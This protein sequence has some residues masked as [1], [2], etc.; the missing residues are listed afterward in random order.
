MQCRREECRTREKSF[1]QRLC[2]RFAEGQERGE[3]KEREKPAE[4]F[5]FSGF[6]RSINLLGRLQIFGWFVG[7]GLTVP[8]GL[9]DS[10]MCR[11]V[12]RHSARFYTLRAASGADG[13]RPIPTLLPERGIFLQAVGR[14]VASRA[15]YLLYR[16]IGTAAT[17]GIYAA[18]TSYPIIFIMAYDRGRGLPRPYRAMIFYCAVGR[19]DLTPPQTVDKTKPA[20]TLCFSG[21]IEIKIILLRGGIFL[22]RTQST[23]CAPAI[24][25]PAGSR[26]EPAPRAASY[27]SRTPSKV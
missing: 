19:G 22:R 5:C 15:V 14:I 13:S 7:N 17:G 23:K 11:E 2:G 6:G 1:S 10:M 12:A 24:S 16:I 25:R 18:P 8:C 27:K 4:T 20:E 26:G 21:S 3:E 9:T